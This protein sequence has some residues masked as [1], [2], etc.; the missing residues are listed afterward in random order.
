MGIAEILT[1][2]FAGKGCPIHPALVHIPVTLIPLAAFMKAAAAGGI[3]PSAPGSWPWHAAHFI[4]GLAV[5]ALIP[6]A[7]TG[8]A[9]Y[10]RLPKD[11]KKVMRKAKM[12]AGL[13]YLV[14][15]ITFYCVWKTSG[16]T[17]KL[18]TQF[19]IILGLISAGILMVSGHLGGE[20]VF[21]HGVGVGRQSKSHSPAWLAS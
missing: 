6:T 17:S 5:L 11:N 3:L 10:T 9:E 16:R 7:I 19:E 2:D 20:M 1:G 21:E 8:M 13:N 4:G 14:A 12:H 15:A 18:P